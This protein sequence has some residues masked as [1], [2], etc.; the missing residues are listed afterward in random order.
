[1]ISRIRVVARIGISIAL[2]MTCLSSAAQ[3]KRPKAKFEPPDGKVIM[4]VGTGWGDEVESY[5]RATGHV[6]AG[7]NLFWGFNGRTNYFQHC[8]QAAPAGAAMAVVLKFV[9]PSGR[10]G[11]NPRDPSLVTEIL[12]GQRD[13]SLETM[14]E[15]FKQAGRP[16]FVNL[17]SESNNSPYITPDGS[18]AAFRYIHD[19][20][21]RLGVA[22]VAYV[23]KPAGGIWRPGVGLINGNYQ[24]FYPGDDYVDWIAGGYYGG[25]P[26]TAQQ[27]GGLKQFHAL[28]ELARQRG[29]P[30]MVA[31]SGPFSGTVSTGGRQTWDSWF[32]PFFEDVRRCGAR[33]VVYNNFALLP[34][35]PKWGEHRI[36][37]MERPIQESWGR[38]MKD[39]MY[40]GASPGLFESLGFGERG[41]DEPKPASVAVG[42]PRQAGRVSSAPEQ[43]TPPTETEK[44]QQAVRVRQIRFSMAPDGEC[45]LLL[46]ARDE[47]VAHEAPQGEMASL[48]GVS[49]GVVRRTEAGLHRVAYAFGEGGSTADFARLGG[50]SPLSMEGISVDR[51]A[52]TLM[53]TPIKGEKSPGKKANFGF[54]RAVKPPLAVDIDFERFDGGTFVLQLNSLVPSGLVVLNLAPDRSRGDVLAEFTLF[55]IKGGK[56]GEAI[57]LLTRRFEV[58]G[59]AES[60]FHLPGGYDAAGDRFTLDFGLHGEESVTIRRLEV[61]GKIPAT[62]GLSLDNDRGGV[63]VKVAL[64]GGACE[65]AGVKDGDVLF[66]INGERVAD[67]KS[68]TS[69][70]ADVPIG[71][72]VRLVVKRGGQ[73]KTIVVKGE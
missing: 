28:S 18:I 37:R 47:A 45:R 7:V 55:P 27:T 48:A 57:N 51:T 42:S 44:K 49:N 43:G 21:K 40:L 38:E 19:R 29:K 61:D 65:K 67:L 73:E 23:W 33:A 31:E 64:K 24:D 46:D 56:R 8:K 72:D 14:A 25:D 58:D 12:S 16:I 39:P 34:D 17:G 22:N 1:M 66:S 5:T 68:A 41:G 13:K 62:F 36:S 11:G 50:T 52:G 63:K 71:Q 3:D 9:Q 69:R 2:A 32:R 59:V 10:D 35:D 20:W 6:P 30:F 53:M 15:A 26:Q 70:L 54:P 60:G 4:I